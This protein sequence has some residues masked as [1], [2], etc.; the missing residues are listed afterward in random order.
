[1][2]KLEKES[3]PNRSQMPKVAVD[4]ETLKEVAPKLPGKIS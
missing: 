4:G 1:M 3:P 2:R